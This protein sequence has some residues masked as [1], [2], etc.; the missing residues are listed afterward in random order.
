MMMKDLKMA[1][2]KVRRKELCCPLPVRLVALFFFLYLIEFFVFKELM[3]EISIGK[4]V[5]AGNKCNS[6]IRTIREE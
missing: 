3:K 5:E 1:L 6:V 2:G 4:Y